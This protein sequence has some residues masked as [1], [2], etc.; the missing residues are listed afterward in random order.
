MAAHSTHSLSVWEHLWDIQVEKTGIC[1]GNRLTFSYIVPCTFAG[2]RSLRGGRLGSLSASE[3][4]RRVSARAA[5]RRSRCGPNTDRIQFTG[6]PPGYASNL[7][8]HAGPADLRAPCAV[9]IPAHPRLSR[10]VLEGS[11]VSRSRR[12]LRLV[13]ALNVLDRSPLRS[14]VALRCPF[15]RKATRTIRAPFRLTAA[16]DACRQR[17]LRSFPRRRPNYSGPSAVIR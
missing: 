12:R 2:S 16:A 9:A 17:D 13:D 1:C 7:V 14:Q 5:C 11:Q 3:A 8:L 10:Q 15:R 4:H 6:G